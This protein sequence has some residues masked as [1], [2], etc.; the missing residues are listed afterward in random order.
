VY[1][2]GLFDSKS[3]S[4]LLMRSVLQAALSLTT[5]YRSSKLGSLS[6]AVSPMFVVVA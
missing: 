3:E 1:L 4:L 2:L 6:V 5:L